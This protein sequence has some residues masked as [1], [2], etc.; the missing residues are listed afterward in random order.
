MSCLAA[1]LGGITSQHEYTFSFVFIW[2]QGGAL[3][4]FAGAS[5]A[6]TARP[7]TCPPIW[8]CRV[9]YPTGTKEPCPVGIDRSPNQWESHLLSWKSPSSLVSRDSWPGP[10]DQ[11]VGRCPARHSWQRWCAD[12]VCV[13]FCCQRCRDARQRHRSDGDRNGIT[14]ADRNEAGRRIFD[15][16]TGTQS[17][18]NNACRVYET[19]GL[20]RSLYLNRAGCSAAFHHWRCA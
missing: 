13:W 9:H 10:E 19:S 17:P 5:P 4:A 20:W 1:H 12:C 2:R 16:G 14:P 6:G 18:Y 8:L 7:G 11:W 3:S 15:P